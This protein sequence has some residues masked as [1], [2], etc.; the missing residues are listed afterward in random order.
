MFQQNEVNIPDA[1]DSMDLEEGVHVPQV[2]PQ[3]LRPLAQ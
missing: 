1:V 2:P 3:Q